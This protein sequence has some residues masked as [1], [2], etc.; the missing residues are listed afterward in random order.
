MHYPMDTH[1]VA[2]KRILRYIK[3]TSAHGLFLSRTSTTILHGYTD[4]DWGGNMDD[5]KSTTGFTIYLGNHLI[6]WSS[7][8]QRVVSRSSTEAEYRARA[9]ATSELTCV[10]FLLCEIG[11]FTSSILIL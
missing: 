10:E 3:C 2:V 5:R 4:S 9:A 11:C 7:R 8:K 1:W 6:S